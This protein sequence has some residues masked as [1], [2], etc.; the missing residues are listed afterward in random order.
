MTDVFHGD[1]FDLLKTLKDN[2]IDFVL[3]DPPY[4]LD[5]LDNL[6]SP[7]DLD[8]KKSNSHIAKLPVGMKF[9]KK[10]GKDFKDF[11]YKLSKEILRVLKPGGF[12]I[13]FSYFTVN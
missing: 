9:D 4:F 5:S 7:L 3:T 8:K 1:C 11:M 10:Q 2:S 6:G 13:S 12:F